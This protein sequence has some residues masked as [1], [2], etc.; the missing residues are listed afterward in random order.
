MDLLDPGLAFLEEDE[1]GVANATLVSSGRKP[2]AD[3]RV[4]TSFDESILVSLGAGDGGVEFWPVH[5][6]SSQ[7]CNKYS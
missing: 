1:T 5:L 2:L 3:E 7:S 6:R 4:S